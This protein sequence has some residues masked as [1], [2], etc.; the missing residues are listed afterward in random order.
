MTNYETKHSSDEFTNYTDNMVYY[1]EAKQELINAVN[2][3]IHTIILY[4]RGG[5]GKSHLTSELTDFLNL[6]GYT[7]MGNSV[8][9]PWGGSF[10][11]RRD[12]FISKISTPEK[13]LI[14]TYYD[15]FEHYNYH[16]SHSHQTINMDHIR[17]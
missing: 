14:H 10:E 2:N 12:Y 8:D 17:F 13:K 5:N 15:V 1:N 16:I 7:I 3:N 4:G 11:L 6:N 9:G